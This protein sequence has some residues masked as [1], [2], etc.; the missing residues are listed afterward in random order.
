MVNKNE[1]DASIQGTLNKTRSRKDRK[2]EGRTRKN[3]KGL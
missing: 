1:A 2:E 3:K